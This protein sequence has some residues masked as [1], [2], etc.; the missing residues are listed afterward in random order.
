MPELPDLT[1]FAENLHRRL[2]GG[3]ITAVHRH[4]SGGRLN[5]SPAELSRALSGAT[6][7]RVERAGKEL[8]FRIGNGRLLY[9]HLMLNGGFRLAA[10]PLQR[11]AGD[12]IISIDFEQGVCLSLHD[13]KGLATV[14]LDPPR[15]QGVPDALDVDAGLLKRL[16]AGKPRTLIKALLIDQKI[17]RGI[18]NAYA[19]EILWQARISPRSSAGKLPDEAVEALA[20]AISSVLLD[21]AQQLRKRHPDMIAGEFREFLAVHNPDRRESP[22]GRSIRVETVSS[23][24]TYFTDEQVLYS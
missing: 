8:C 5:V 23:K 22:G 24:K 15:D 14:S 2:A 18:G 12:A 13:P 10:Q 21:A 19:D 6:I 16:I 11:S 9:I 17:I 4:G 3:R 1:V 20:A 7:E